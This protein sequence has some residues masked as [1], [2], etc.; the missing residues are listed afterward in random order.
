MANAKAKGVRIGKEIGIDVFFGLES[1]YKGTDFLI[2][3][4]DKEWLLSHPEIED[5][6]KVEML[7]FMAEAGALVIQAHP[8]R[9]ANYINHIRLFPR[10]VHG[11]ET[12]NAQR[13][14]FENSMAKHYAQSYGLIEFA[15]S[16]NHRGSETVRLGGMQSDTPITDELDFVT[17]VKSGEITPFSLNTA[18]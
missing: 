14:D 16:D 3:G 15:G 5:M 9:E 4:L 8:F 18:K 6:K 1:S 11:V 17:R 13:T 12:Y 2:Y 10:H 7:P